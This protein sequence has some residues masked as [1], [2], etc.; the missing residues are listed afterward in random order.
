M[1]P[2]SSGRKRHQPKRRPHDPSRTRRKAAREALPPELI[3]S[4]LAAG[5][6]LVRAAGA[7]DAE[8]I[9]SD[10][11]DVWSVP[12]GEEGD[13]G[14][15]RNMA[16]VAAVMIAEAIRRRTTES[17]TLLTA[18]A[19]VSDGPLATWA[20]DGVRELQ[21]AGL[22]GPPWLG[23]VGRARPVSAYR[24]WDE[25]GDGLSIVIQFAYDVEEPHAV[26]VLI[27]RNLGC[28]VKNVLVADRGLEV[29]ELYQKECA[30]NPLMKIE[31]IDL[32]QARGLVEDA[33]AVTDR[34]LRH[35]PPIDPNVL[36]YRAL[37]LSRM[38]L[39]P[40]PS[41]R[42]DIAGLAPRWPEDVR[43]PVALSRP[44]DPDLAQD[45]RFYGEA[46]E[47]E[48]DLFLAT[49]EVVALGR[50]LVVT[51][52]VEE[53]FEWSSM[54]DDGR[55]LRVSAAK[56]ELLL[57]DW[58]PKW[59]DLRASHIAVLPQVL[60]LWC[61]HAAAR[62]GTPPA[63]LNEALSSI[64]KSGP[65]LQAAVA[66]AQA[67]GFGYLREHVYGEDIWERADEVER[68]TFS[69][70]AEPGP[71]FDP[72]RDEEGL[73][74]HKISALAHPDF[75]PG[76][77]LDQLEPL[78]LYEDSDPDFETKVE[79]ILHLLLH[80]TVGSQLW[81]DEPPELWQTVRRLQHGGYDAHSIHHMLMAAISD[82]MRRTVIGG[83]PFDEALAFAQLA[84]LPG[85]YEQ[86]TGRDRT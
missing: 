12:F 70:L 46:W 69:L 22:T 11:V 40:E 72:M 1:S 24:N 2:K 31:E 71:D 35:D 54:L 10:L 73:N 50:P 17:L 53:I 23:Q 78:L 42:P 60:T 63:V 5:R 79:Q 9:A 16:S 6:D 34:A 44:G 52:C 18:I 39:L 58:L 55:L 7:L 82:P 47:T 33:L 27:D 4:L 37:V 80:D 83:E 48:M 8:C 13:D 81:E 56:N 68:L 29:V 15:E 76:L 30:R 75:H 62:A 57:T 20:A 85:F 84:A 61:R 51:A 74:L 86:F 41:P 45:H 49:S 59:A 19:A 43:Q 32:A 36:S 25:A 38:P 3:S 64:A 14:T 21:Q 67:A 66:A 26:C 28:L 77:E 65:G